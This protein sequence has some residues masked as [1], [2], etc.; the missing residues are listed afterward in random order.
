MPEPIGRPRQLAFAYRASKST[1]EALGR[2][3]ALAQSLDMQLT[4]FVPFVRPTDSGACCGFEAA[5]WEQLLREAAHD[6]ARAAEGLL[7]AAAA[8]PVVVVEGRSVPEIVETF[9][10]DGTERV[11]A[12]PEK[13]SAS[14]FSRR[15]LHQL[16]R[17]A[18][19]TVRQLPAR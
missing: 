3:V 15:A 5:R 17:H 12:L 14:P 10:G 9:I 13:A 7:G 18:G 19:R 4:V 16:A 6:E 11:L 8:R 2:A 1:D